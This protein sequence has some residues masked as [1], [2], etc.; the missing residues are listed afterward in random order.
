MRM[1]RSEDFTHPTVLDA[2]VLGKRDKA[3]VFRAS[4]T[5]DET[6]KARYWGKREAWY[7]WDGTP[8]C[9]DAMD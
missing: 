5:E 8:Q 4:R 7:V 6:G 1:V 3:R 9:Q 2:T